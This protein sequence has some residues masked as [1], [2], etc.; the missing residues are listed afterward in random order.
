M[1]GS[2][3]ETDI[4]RVLAGIKGIVRFNEPMRSHTSFRIGGPADGYVEP[5]DVEALRVLMAR[6]YDAKIPVFVMGGTNLLVRDGGIEGLVVRLVK[7]TSVQE[8]EPGL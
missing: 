8:V 5:A 2:I 7:F 3:K 1:Q 4:R 6:A